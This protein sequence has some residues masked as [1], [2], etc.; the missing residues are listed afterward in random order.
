MISSRYWHTRFA[1]DPGVVGRTVRVNNVVPTIVGVIA[2]DFTGIQQPLSDVP[3]ISLPLAL[4][5]QMD[6]SSGETPRLSQPTYWWLQV[7]GRLKPGA[8]GGAGAR[9]PRTVAV[10]TAGL[11]SSVTNSIREAVKELDPN[12]P[13]MD[14]STQIE[15]V[16]RRFGQEKVFAKAYTLFG[17]LA[18]SLA[19]IGLF[20]L[21]SYSVSRRTNEIGVRMALG[22]QRRDVPRLVMR[23]SLILVAAGIAVGVMIA[24]GASQLVATLLFGLAGTDPM[25]I[26]AW[27]FARRRPP[28]AFRAFRLEA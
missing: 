23:E 10:R 7:M 25:T 22:A 9:Q 18:L 15:Q 4:D 28:F 26:A 5:P 17:G 2:P 19:A 8:T 6:T 12:L 21:M 3:D 13:M 11:P 24:V 1:T 20:G 16:E 27:S 14:V